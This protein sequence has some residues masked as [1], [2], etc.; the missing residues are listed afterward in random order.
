MAS[1]SGVEDEQEPTRKDPLRVVTELAGLLA[2]VAA[3]IYGTGAVVLSLRLA[4]EHL[5]WSNIVSG[6]PRE[7]LLST[8][9]G[10][11]L[12]PSLAI[13]ALYGLFRAL[14]K[15]DGRPP[16][17]LGIWDRATFWAL[18]PRCL[19][20]AVVLLLPLLFVQLVRG[21][22]IA[23]GGLDPWL[24]LGLLI[25]LLLLAIAV[26]RGRSMA[27]ARIS[28]TQRWDSFRAIATMA[29][30]YAVA[31]VPATMLAAAATPLTSARACLKS[32]GIETGK[33]VGESGERVY[34][35][36][37]E[38]TAEQTEYHRI[39]V[40]PTAEIDQLIVGPQPKLATCGE[41]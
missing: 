28:A 16:A 29:A 2:A 18:L 15:G 24:G 26:Q 22:S 21:T 12:L 25:V 5:P 1:A 11:V 31:A 39:F 7:F 27:I 33:I 14:Q 3:V 36:E 4:L 20:T 9:A 38:I 41:S 10:Q 23:A 6:L 13:G 19:G 34:L 30:L 35:G 17:A 40:I 37:R 32:G 8:G